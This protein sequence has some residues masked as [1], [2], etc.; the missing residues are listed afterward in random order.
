[1]ARKSLGHVKLEWTCSNCGTKN[2]GPQKTCSG[3]G[4]PQPEDVKFEQPKRQEL[5]KDEAVIAKAK[6]GPDVHCGFCGARN[7][8]GTTICSQCGADLKEGK[9]RVS[10][11]VLGA[12]RSGPA[13]QVSCPHCGALNL[14]TVHKC[15]EC[16]GSLALPSA[17]PEEPAAKKAEPKA[18]RK[19]K[20]PIKAVFILIG[21]VICV[22]L[23]LVLFGLFSP[24]ENILG[25]VQNVSW[26][27]TIF[28]EEY[29]DVTKEDWRDEIPAGADIGSCE[30][31]EH[32]VQDD[33]APNAK[34]VC[35]TPYT[36][37]EGSGFGEVVQDCEYHVYLDYC[38]YTI[39]EWAEVDKT[40]L[41]GNN[42]SP[43]WPE[44]QLTS[45][46]RL[47]DRQEEQYTVV[48]T[49][50]EGTYQYNTSDPDLFTQCLVG[51]E[52]ILNINVFDSVVSIESAK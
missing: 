43:T 46:Q 10:G 35:G 44:P 37:D 6:A 36:V 23:A 16:G 11:Q 22:G 40:T 41:S 17:E 33:P 8:A 1:M 27:R 32:H 13:E 30:Q 45:D 51:S 31:K 47:S 14:D 24:K 21:L 9:K 38:E 7:P 4:S 42:L 34:E 12:F 20:S 39:Q 18:K 25:T 52:W 15:K 48:F 5:I 28:I 2:P 19:T 26:E 3:C 49:T 29:G 50:E